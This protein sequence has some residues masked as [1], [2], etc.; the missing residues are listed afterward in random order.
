MPTQIIIVDIDAYDAT[1]PGARTLRYSTRGYA[2]APADS[3]ANTYYDDRI[4]QPWN[5]VRSIFAD[6]RTFGRSQVGYGEIVL[7]NSDGGLDALVDY[8]FSGRAIT[9]KQ[10]LLSD[11]GVVTSWTTLLT[12]TMEQAV[13]TWQRITIRVRDKMADLAQPLQKLL[14]GGTNALPNGID[15]VADDLE[16]RPKPLVYGQVFNIAPPCVNTTRLIYQL[17]DGSA[18]QSVDGVYDRGVP[19]TAGA[20]YASQAAMEATAPTAGQY[21]VWNSAA[22]CYVRLG[23]TP[24]GLVTADATQGATAA[25]RTV[26]QLWKLVLLKAGVLVGDIT[27]ADVTALDAAAAYPVG[28]YCSSTSNMTALQAADMLVA[29]VGA[30]YGPDV[31]GKWRIARVVVPSGAG[32]GTLTS[33]EVLKIDRLA[34][35]DPGAGV[36]A[37]LVK[38]RYKP[39]WAVQVDIGSAVSTDR[40]SFLGKDWRTKQVSDSAVLTANPTSPEI[41]F[42]TYLVLEADAAAEASRRLTIYKTRRDMLQVRVYADPALAAVLDIGKTVVLQLPRYGFAAGKPLLVISV[43]SD[44]RANFFDLVLWG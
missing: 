29:S 41:S 22:G 43:R 20:T 2:T 6:A 18:L 31:L 15:G 27:A 13:F 21:R 39:L 5:M 28:I 9:I 35:S 36:P 32:I 42:D 16:G 4:I 26:A 30:W 24:T 14:Y 8:G 19:L 40:A 38:L 37:Y 1:L 7:A 3:P 10:G 11:A 17:H 33:T 25:A 12:G 44:L 23:S 34:P